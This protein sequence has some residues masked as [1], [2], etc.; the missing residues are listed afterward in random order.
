M[1]VV[2]QL[3]AGDTD[4]FVHVSR[5][6]TFNSLVSEY[7]THVMAVDGV[8]IHRRSIAVGQRSR[9]DRHAQ[10]RRSVLVQVVRQ[11]LPKVGVP[12]RAS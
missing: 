7:N 10:R 5:D 1:T 8:K 3:A 9:I 12:A 11:E 2:R 6:F 4:A